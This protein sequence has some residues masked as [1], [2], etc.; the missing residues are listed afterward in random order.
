MSLYAL[1]INM[2]NI[3]KTNTVMLED[4]LVRVNVNL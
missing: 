3:L 4:I 2:E 1:I